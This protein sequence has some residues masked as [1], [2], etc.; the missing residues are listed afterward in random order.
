MAKDQ[1]YSHFEA[2]QWA[3]VGWNAFHAMAIKAGTEKAWDALPVNVRQAQIGIARDAVLHAANGPE[4]AYKEA[5]EAW[6]QVKL[7]PA[8]KPVAAPEPSAPTTKPLKPGKK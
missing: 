3:R 2:E 6:K 7:A 1:L 8:S 4:L 5:F